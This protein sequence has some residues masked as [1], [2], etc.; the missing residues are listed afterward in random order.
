MR[1]RINF[2]ILTAVIGCL[3]GLSHGMVYQPFDICTESAQVDSTQQWTVV[4]DPVMAPTPPP[5]RSIYTI[6][7]QPGTCMLAKDFFQGYWMDKPNIG[8]YT[9]RP[10]TKTLDYVGNFS[11]GTTGTGTD[12]YPATGKAKPGSL[13]KDSTDVI[14]FGTDETGKNVT[15]TTRTAAL[16][17]SGYDLFQVRQRVGT[18]PWTLLQQDSVVANGAGKIIYSTGNVNAVTTCVLKGRTYTCTPVVTSAPEPQW[19]EVYYLTLTGDRVDSLRSYNQNGI[20]IMTTKWFWSN[21]SGTRIV[22]NARAFSPRM[23]N[24]GAAFDITGRKYLEPDRTQL[25]FITVGARKY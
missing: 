20:H 13:G 11:D 24:P 7:Y 18:G 4:E 3:L 17:K 21:R 12:Y 9:L 8:T 15:R 1:L 2:K 10:G 14:E 16:A 25:R 22:E 23:A 19:T 5:Y 6:A